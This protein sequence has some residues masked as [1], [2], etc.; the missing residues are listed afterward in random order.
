MIQVDQEL[1]AKEVWER[2]CQAKELMAQEPVRYVIEFNGEPIEPFSD[3]LKAAE[4][5]AIG[6][7]SE[8]ELWIPSKDPDTPWQQMK[9]DWE[10][11]DSAAE[12]APAADP[13]RAVDT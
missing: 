3:G 1:T 10:G 11:V 8:V 7:R 13:R 12:D 5:L 6:E 2:Y 9:S 4:Q